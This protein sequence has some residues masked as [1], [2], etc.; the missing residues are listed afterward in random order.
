MQS[1][2][3]PLLPAYRDHFLRALEKLVE[4]KERYRPDGWQRLQE[5]VQES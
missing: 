1:T 4:G 5:A 2:W 3:R